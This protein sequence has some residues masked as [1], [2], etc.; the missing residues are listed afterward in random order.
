M[1]EGTDTCAGAILN[2]VSITVCA[3]VQMRELDLSTLEWRR[4]DTKGTP[5]PYKTH[6]STAV[7]AEKWIIHGGRRGGK[8]N[9][10]NHTTVFDFTTLR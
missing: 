10:T 7:V 6:C 3:N 8:Y 4:V 9:V 5:P 1:R 2:N